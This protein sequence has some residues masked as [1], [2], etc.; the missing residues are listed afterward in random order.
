[1]KL[2]IQIPCFN[3]AEFIKQTLEDLPL[4]IPGIDQIETLVIDDGSQDNTSGIARQAGADHV[5]TIP[6]H[7]GLAQAYAMGL[8]MA[9]KNGADIIVNTDADN[10]YLASGIEV[11]NIFHLPSVGCKR[12]AARWSQ[13]QQVSLF[14]M[15]PVVSVRSP[16]IWL[17]IQMF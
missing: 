17:C 3:E 9:L 5:L 15:P 4:Q 2:I 12:L 6:H 8:D 14:L 13:K 10:Q 7:V 11:S 16:V 1:M